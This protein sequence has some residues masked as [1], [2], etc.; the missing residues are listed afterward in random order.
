MARSASSVIL[1]QYF[2][3]ARESPGHHTALQRHVEQ[4][5]RRSP[6]ANRTGHLGGW[7][8]DDQRAGYG[9]HWSAARAVAPVAETYIQAGT[10]W[11]YWDDV[12]PVSTDWQS[13]V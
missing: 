10:E 5:A 8:I 13:R 6:R 12:Q 4:C 11:K 2:D 3:G 9:R 1:V 7:R